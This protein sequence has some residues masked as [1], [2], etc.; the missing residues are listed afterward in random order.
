M[1]ANWIN[2][3]CHLN[4]D[5]EALVRKT[6]YGQA[7]FKQALSLLRPIVFP[8]VLNGESEAKKKQ[9]IANS[10]VQTAIT[11]FKALTIGGNDGSS[12]ESGVTD[13]SSVLSNLNTFS[14][15]FG[16][17]APAATASAAGTF[18]TGVGIAKAAVD[19]TTALVKIN[20]PDKSLD[21]EKVKDAFLWLLKMWV[22]FD[23]L[24]IASQRAC[25]ENFP[26]SSSVVRSMLG[27]VN[28]I[29]G[30][31]DAYVQKIVKGAQTQQPDPRVCTLFQDVNAEAD[32]DSTGV[33]RFLVD[34]FSVGFNGLMSTLEARGIDASYAAIVEEFPTKDQLASMETPFKDALEEFGAAVAKSAV[35]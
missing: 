2:D 5:L 21:Y 1:L 30:S 19:L 15:L 7:T 20:W 13:L 29:V 35:N 6:Y 11:A 4:E 25:E 16:S 10:D 27:T 22:A 14:Q 24:T 33:S 23:S 28:D 17:S 26:L 12:M 32:K 31:K 3:F 18:I 34:F 8:P 9:I